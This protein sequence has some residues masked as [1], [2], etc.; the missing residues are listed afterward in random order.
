MN[1]AL[2]GA[3]GFLGSYVLGLLS[4]RNDVRRVICFLRRELPADQPSSGKVESKIVRFSREDD[5]E[6]AVEKVDVLFHLAA[7]LDSQSDD[8]F[9]FNVGLTKRLARACKINGVKMVFCSSATVLKSKFPTPYSESKK[10]AEAVVRSEAGKFV[11]VRPTWVL[12][13]KSRSW[14]NLVHQLRRLPV[15]PIIGNGLTCIRPLYIGDCGRFIVDSGLCVGGEAETYNLFGPESLNYND[16]MTGLLA[17]LGVRKK[18]L[19]LPMALGWVLSRYLRA[20]SMD[21]FSD[22]IEDISHHT[23]H[24][25][26][27]VKPGRPY[28]SFLSEILEVSHG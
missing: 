16:L 5:I 19:H 1:V 8:L 26:K 27:F 20:V 22:M 24:L 28:S 14:N 10:A 2:T 6:Q 23:N 13:P 11:I 25:E 3:T 17:H 9:E 7:V 18:I 4:N 15:I 12:G 21:A